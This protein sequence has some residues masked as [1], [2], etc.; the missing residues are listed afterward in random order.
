MSLRKINIAFSPGLALTK[1]KSRPCI[2]HILEW[3]SDLIIGGGERKKKICELNYHPPPKKKS[4]K[5]TF[6]VFARK[7][8]RRY[9]KKQKATESHSTLERNE[10]QI[11]DGE[12]WNVFVLGFPRRRR[13]NKLEAE[14]MGSFSGDERKNSFSASILVF[15]TVFFPI[16][17]YILFCVPTCKN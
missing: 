4:R 5:N 16:G 2:S 15:L 1:I 3:K 13:R 14:I 17:T 6:P 7:K 10:I 11:S 12:I 8:T 9:K